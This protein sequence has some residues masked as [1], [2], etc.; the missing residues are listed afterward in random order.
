MALV[1][2]PAAAPEHV[3]EAAL[4]AAVTDVLD[5]TALMSVATTLPGGGPW[6]NN[7]YFAYDEDFRLYFLSR[8]QTA[9]SRNL[10]ADDAAAGGRVAVAVADSQQPAIPGRRR[11]VQLEGRCRVAAADVHRAITAFSARFPG[12]AAVAATTAAP[13]PTD[14]APR[15]YVVT[16]AAF[17][18]FH[19]PVLGTDVWLSGRVTGDASLAPPARA[20][21]SSPAV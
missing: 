16:V 4:V 17:K 9:H 15:L 10:R 7:A 8:P 2:D 14:R 21:L 19:E 11:G 12:F 1:W 5:G 6:I 18:L 3:D 20:A 13:D